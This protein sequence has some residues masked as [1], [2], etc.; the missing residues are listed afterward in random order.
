MIYATRQDA[1]RRGM[2]SAGV[3]ALLVTSLTNVRYLCGFAG[4]NGQLLIT[5]G[6]AILL[7]DPRYEQR[8]GSMTQGAEVVIY[9]GRY[10]ETSWAGEPG[11][12]LKKAM[13]DAGAS[14]LGVEGSTMTVAEERSLQEQG[15][16]PVATEGLVEEVRRVKDDTEI[17]SI[18]EAVRVA[19]EAFLHIVEQISVGKTERDIALRLEM[20]MRHHGAQAISFDPIVGSGP[21]SAHIHHSPS[22]RVFEKGD[23]ILCDFGALVDG[24]CS[25]LTRTV[26][27]G[28]ASDEQ[29]EVYRLVLAAQQAGIDALKAGVDGKAV[30][31]AARKVIED[32]GYGQRFGHGLGHGVG[33][34]IHEAPRLSKLSADTL[35]TNEVVT[36]EPGIY[37]PGEGGIRIEDCVLV[38]ETGAE[39]LGTAPKAE[40]LEL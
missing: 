21:L 13:T 19:D 3:D 34:D 1:L 12:L 33:L 32:A 17:E 40:L 7:T 28:P 2:E 39:V 37:V 14:T 25:D 5:A 29:K 4:S 6:S 38:T 30:D 9:G 24:Y 35:Q 26:V 15:V 11:E 36:V 23:L 20:F 31:A 18:R 16:T 27:L 8:A 10:S 22:D